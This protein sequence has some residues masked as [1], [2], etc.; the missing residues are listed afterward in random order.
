MDKILLI[1]QREYLSRVKKKSF[2]VMTFLVPILFIGMFV[3]VGYLVA[4]QNELGDLK[5]IEV[6][7]ES[8]LFAGKLRNNGTLQYTFTSD[9]YAKARAGL[10]KSDFDYLLYVPSSA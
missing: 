6:V 5:K 7:D 9:S 2:I 10:L 8:G 4:K 3:L 1:I